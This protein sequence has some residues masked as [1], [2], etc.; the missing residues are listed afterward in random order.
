[1]RVARVATLVVCCLLFAL[2][3]VFVFNVYALIV[4]IA[5]LLLI[6]FIV[7]FLN[8]R[9]IAIKEKEIVVIGLRTWHIP[10]DDI[11]DIQ[12]ASDRRGII[13]IQT[14]S[15]VIRSAGYLFLR[16]INEERNRELVQK[17]SKWCRKYG[18]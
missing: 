3:M 7:W 10:L 1:M 4:G 14:K 11:V 16:D 2:L 8:R 13:V 6:A 18:H 12:C 5:M 9:S 15:S 17:L